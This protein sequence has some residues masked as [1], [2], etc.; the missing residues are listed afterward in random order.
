M[1]DS[2]ISLV[3]EVKRADVTPSSSVNLSSIMQDSDLNNKS[4]SDV[5]YA[6][7]LIN[8]H[9]RLAVRDL[10]KAL[11]F[12]NDIIR[13]LR[14][15]VIEDSTGSSQK[16]ISELYVMYPTA[17][18]D[19]VK[20]KLDF[21]NKLTSR[22][23]INHYLKL[24]NAKIKRNVLDKSLHE[25]F[26][27]KDLDGLINNI[28]A[29]TENITGSI[30]P[31]VKLNDILLSSIKDSFDP[32]NKMTS[33]VSKLN[34]CSH[35]KALLKGQLIIVAAPPGVGKSQFMINE[36]YIHAKNGY[37]VVYL[38]LGDALESDFVIKLGCLHF[39][40][41]VEQFIENIDKYIVDPEF[42]R[43]QG[44]IKLSVMSAG[45]VKSDDIR[46]FYTADP[47]I[48]NADV[49]FFDY[50]SNFEDLMLYDMYKAHDKIY[51]NV[52]SLARMEGK[53][54]LVY[55][56]SQVKPSYYQ[57]EYIPQNALAESSR[58]PAIA[59]YVVTLSGIR[60]DNKNCGMINICK[61]R[62]GKIGNVPYMLSKSGHII[63]TDMHTYR[64]MKAEL[65]ALKMTEDD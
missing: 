58:K 55:I 17:Y 2:A 64:T 31:F 32:K 25:Y 13:D 16:I 56:A 37:I 21:Y 36:T 1:N 10:A 35:Y 11:K 5:D 7:M 30:I 65:K 47:E 22:E 59:D 9:I 6:A 19:A 14:T 15:L 24:L 28:D 53:P 39:N 62:R 51:N 27:D 41:T 18:L 4:F 46:R 61:V 45:V 12:P 50:D 33:S 23:D 34:T 44:N 42:N 38:A 57:T 48:S 63:E 60:H 40:V 3:A 49:Y 8:T 43:I 29:L 54:K 52:Y 20:D 26:D